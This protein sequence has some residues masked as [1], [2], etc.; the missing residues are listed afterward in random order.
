MRSYTSSDKLTRL[1]PCIPVGR[2]IYLLHDAG[3]SRLLEIKIKYTFVYNVTINREQENVKSFNGEEVNTDSRPKETR[4]K[5]DMVME[6]MMACLI[7]KRL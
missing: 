5:L 4:V 7:Q 3:R 6:R 2:L 1:P